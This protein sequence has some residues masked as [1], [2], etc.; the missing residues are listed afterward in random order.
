MKFKLRNR[1]TNHLSIVVQML[2][3]ASILYIIP[4][5]GMHWTMENCSLSLLLWW[6]TCVQWFFWK[7]LKVLRRVAI[8][9][10][11]QMFANLFFIFGESQCLNVKMATLFVSIIMACSTCFFL[12]LT[13]FLLLC[14][15]IL[16]F[17]LHCCT[18]IG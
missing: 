11:Q 3:N 9:L 12:Q 5:W 1:L 14:I 18:F 7:S 15:M 10:C 17:V 4:I 16:D 6:V 13:I 2:R 8:F